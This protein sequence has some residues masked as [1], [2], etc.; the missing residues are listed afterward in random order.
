MKRAK[1]TVEDQGQS[2]KPLV[3]INGR[4]VEVD[5]L[6]IDTDYGDMGALA[7]EF[8]TRNASVVPRTTVTLTLPID[9]ITY[10]TKEKA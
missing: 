8:L 1:I 2:I 4:T 9:Q 10:I 3:R 5:D 6:Q 7:F